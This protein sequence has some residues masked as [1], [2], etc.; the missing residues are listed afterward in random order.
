[1]AI[2]GLGGANAPA[3]CGLEAGEGGEVDEVMVG[4]SLEGLWRAL[5][6]G[7]ASEDGERASASG[8]V[9]GARLPRQDL[10]NT[11]CHQAIVKSENYK[12]CAPTQLK[13]PI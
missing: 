10:N 13:H 1:M 2:L 9:A 7:S 5:V 11:S 8:V 12:F 3:A 4:R 6:C